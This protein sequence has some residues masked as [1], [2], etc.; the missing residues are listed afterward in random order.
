MPPARSGVAWPSLYVIGWGRLGSALGTQAKA[1]GVPLL[2]VETRDPARRRA[3][4]R[5]L[6]GASAELAAADLVALAVPDG[7][8]AAVTG[9]LLPRLRAKQV[10]FHLGGSTDLAPL[11]ALSTVGALAGSLHPFCSVASARSP[12]A[13]S[14]C[15]LDGP[16]LARAR[17]RRLALAVGLRPL[18]RPP[19]DRIRYHLAAVFLVASAGVSALAAERLLRA[20][21]ASATEARG[22]IGAILRSVAF[23]LERDLSPAALTG[24][25]VRGD[26]GRIERQLAALRDDP[27]AAA[28]YRTLGT[29]SA[30]LAPHLPAALRSAVKRLLT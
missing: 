1:A 30:D 22:A 13:G 14:T 29:Q 25:F 15:A 20:I 26:L 28:L 5:A 2:G 10:V 11:A 27:G 19:T 16:P 17:L 24:P 12:L 21:G 18:A 7:A 4:R 6:G 3:A 9:S 8:L 23:N